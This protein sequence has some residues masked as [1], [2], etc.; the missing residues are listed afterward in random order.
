ME[1]IE[2]SPD[3]REVY[4]AEIPELVWSTGPVSYEY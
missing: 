3:V 2:V 4:A 1:I